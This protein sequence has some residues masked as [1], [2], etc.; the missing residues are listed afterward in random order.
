M[1][2]IRAHPANGLEDSDG[3]AI[4]VPTSLRSTNEGATIAGI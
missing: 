1:G 3:E 4:M 2:S